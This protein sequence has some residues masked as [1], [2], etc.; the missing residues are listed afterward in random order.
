MLLTPKFGTRYGNYYG[1]IN[2][3]FQKVLKYLKKYTPKVGYHYLM[4]NFTCGGNLCS[5]KTAYRFDELL[6]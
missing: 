2:F 1:V 6:N 3:Y 5:F 4:L